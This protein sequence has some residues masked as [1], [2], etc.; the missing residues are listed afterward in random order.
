MAQATKDRPQE[1]RSGT[2]QRQQ[3]QQAPRA[4]VREVQSPSIQPKEASPINDYDYDTLIRE[5]NT[6][7]GVIRFLSSQGYS[8][9]EISQFTGLRYQH[10]R[11]VLLMPL[12]SKQPATTE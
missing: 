4:P 3:Q 5:H 12:T 2:Q 1:V 6:K 8:R 9:S 11:N 7:S 10:V